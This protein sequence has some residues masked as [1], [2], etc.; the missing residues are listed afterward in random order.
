MRPY[1]N[2]PYQV[3]TKKGKSYGYYVHHLVNIQKDKES[4]DYILRTRRSKNP[5]GDA[6]LRSLASGLNEKYYDRYRMKVT[7]SRLSTPMTLIPVDEPKKDEIMT[8]IPMED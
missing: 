3:K 5:I 8:L 1:S 6:F 4:E 2:P 7:K